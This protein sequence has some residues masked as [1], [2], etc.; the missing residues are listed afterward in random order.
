MTG[1]TDMV[2]ASGADIAFDDVDGNLAVR[3][4]ERHTHAST[5]HVFNTHRAIMISKSKKG[6]TVL[7][8]AEDGLEIKLVDGAVKP[9]A[10]TRP[11][12][13]FRRYDEGQEGKALVK[14][15]MGEVG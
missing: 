10:G 5:L 7:R 6:S 3:L 9:T 14:P 1:N 2:F 11:I 4:A 8:Q 15:R 13:V 12:P